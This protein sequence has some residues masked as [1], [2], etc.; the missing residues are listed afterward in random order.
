MFAV[1][2]FRLNH[3]L[4][5]SSLN[6]SVQKPKFDLAASLSRPMTWKRHTGKLQPFKQENVYK[7]PMGVTEAS[8]NM[9]AATSK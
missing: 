1:T 9:R 4:N 8:N 7:E 5:K 6:T 3:T 2:P